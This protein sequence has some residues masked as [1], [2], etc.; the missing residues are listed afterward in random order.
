LG[1]AAE[2][3]DPLDID[4]MAK[5]INKVLSKPE[6]RKELIRKGK[7]QAAKYSWRRMAEQTLAIYKQALGE[8]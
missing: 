5:V 2:Y 7:K 8:K 3:F 4:N 1:D 6:L